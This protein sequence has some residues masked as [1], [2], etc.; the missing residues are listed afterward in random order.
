MSVGEV[1]ALALAIAASPFPVVPAIL[2]LFTARP[3][4]T[5]LAFLGG[6]FGGIGLVTA[7][8]ALLAEAIGSGGDSP[9]WLSWVRIVV[10]A[11]LVVVGVRQWVGRRAADGPPAW[12]RSI[13]DAT[14][15]TAVRLALLLSVANPKVVLLAAAAGLDLGTA[16]LSVAREIAAV[17]GFT[18]VASIT[19]AIPVLLHAV[20][21]ARVLPPLRTA[22][23][24]LLRNNAAVM[25]VVITAIGLVLIKNGVTGL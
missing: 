25:A 8:F 16:G 18:A 19:V 21:G 20:L 12:M 5:S 24:W 9:A 15:R 6:W 22:K 2:L 10:G 1:L 13:Q 4:P 14:P 11:V 17:V 23:D 3:R 7:V